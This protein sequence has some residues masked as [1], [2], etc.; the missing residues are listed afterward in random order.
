MVE[1][2]LS[3]PQGDHGYDVSNYF[4]VDPLFGTL[5]ELKHAIEEFHH[6]GMAVLLDIVPNHVSSQHPWFISA[7]EVAMA[8]KL[9]RGSSS[10][11]A[12]EKAGNPAERLEKR[13]WRTSM[14][15][16]SHR[17][18]QTSTLVPAYSMSANQT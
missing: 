4:D 11:R 13:V 17:G 5:E 14:V 16:I 18:R 3:I 10:D 7:K 8:M 2:N 6:H 12:R 1:S 9:S 15:Q